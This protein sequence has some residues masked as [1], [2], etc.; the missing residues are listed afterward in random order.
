[1]T[2]VLSLYGDSR[3][4]G[5]RVANASIISSLIVAKTESIVSL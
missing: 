5:P 2:I 4:R 3:A 1:M